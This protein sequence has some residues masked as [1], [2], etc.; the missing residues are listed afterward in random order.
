M[1][2]LSFSVN[3]LNP[4]HFYSISSPI[5]TKP[6]DNV[7]IPNSTEEAWPPGNMV[8]PIELAMPPCYSGHLFPKPACTKVSSPFLCTQLEDAMDRVCMTKSFF[9]SLLFDLNSRALL[10]Q[11]FLSS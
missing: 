9:F 1:H 6:I 2:L 5:P 8:H 11:N 4:T 10:L 7:M 3:T